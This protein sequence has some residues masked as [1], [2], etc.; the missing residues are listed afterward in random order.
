MTLN[1]LHELESSLTLLTG[2]SDKG[3]EDVTRFFR[4]LSSVEN[5]AKA[6]VQ[7]KASGCLLFNNWTAEIQYVFTVINLIFICSKN[8]NAQSRRCKQIN[9]VTITLIQQLQYVKKQ[10]R[11][12]TCLCSKNHRQKHSRPKVKKMKDKNDNYNKQNYTC[13]KQTAHMY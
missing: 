2:K 11:K 4:V 7:L 1:E 6:Y 3:K 13:F 12:W 5:L 9:L 8:A 10:R